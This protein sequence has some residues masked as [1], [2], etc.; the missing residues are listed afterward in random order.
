MICT[1]KKKTGNGLVKGL[2][3][4]K[5]VPKNNPLTRPTSS[6]CRKRGFV[7]SKLFFVGLIGQDFFACFNNMVDRHSWHSAE[8]L[9]PI[10]TNQGEFSGFT[11]WAPSWGCFEM[12]LCK[13]T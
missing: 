4:R 3:T 9:G 11:R 5:L 6:C 13:T 10:P 8:I 2:L 12:E 7:G 1:P